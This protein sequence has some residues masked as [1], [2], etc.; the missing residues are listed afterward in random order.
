[1]KHRQFLIAS[2]LAAT[3]GMLSAQANAKEVRIGLI[4][5]L[6]GATGAQGQ[7]IRDG[8]ELAVSEA[9]GKLGGFDTKLI[10]NDSQSRPDLALQAANKL[11]EQDKVQILTGTIYSSIALAIAKP[12]I[13]NKVFYISPN[14]GPSQL[15]GKGCSPYFFNTSWQGEQP[16]E[17]MG[18]YLQELSVKSVYLIVPNHAAGKDSVRGFKH[19]YKGNVIGETYVTLNQL[20]FAA[21]ISK[22]RAANPDALYA[23]LPAAMGINFTKQYA[24]AG[25]TDKIPMYSNSTIDNISLPA[26]GDAA[27]GTYQSNVW[28]TDFPNDANKNF[29]KNFENK[30][31]YSPTNFAALSYDVARMIDSALRQ[32]GGIDNKEAFAAALKKAKFDSVRGP[33]A[34]NTNNYPIGNYYVLKTIRG[35]DGKL[36]Q[37]TEKKIL[38]DFKDAYYKECSMK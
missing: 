38:S 28:N 31:G 1:M 24:Q 26:I 13:E 15:A 19:A 20:D 4:T 3:V 9:G 30:Y 17:A 18:A 32:A 7:N 2:A 37:V 34:F 12:A 25:L 14:A 35:S 33:F 29:V 23:F 10:V 8:F 27:E 36:V 5:T 6:S 11:I 21:E 16:H 22:I